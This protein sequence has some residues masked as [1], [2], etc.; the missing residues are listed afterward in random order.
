M[1]KGKSAKKASVGMSIV[2]FLM[3]LRF[4]KKK[5]TRAPELVKPG[6][7]PREVE[8]NTVQKIE[9]IALHCRVRACARS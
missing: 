5:R 9:V 2:R 4:W 3:R 6:D 7:Q 1:N 8:T